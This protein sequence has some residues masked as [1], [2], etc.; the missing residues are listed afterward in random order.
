VTFFL[1]LRAHPL[2]LIFVRHTDPDGWLR[3]AVA[4]AVFDKNF[5]PMK[6]FSLAL[7]VAVCA[8]RV[9]MVLPDLSSP[10]LFVGTMC[11]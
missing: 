2:V 10:D 3:A 7:Q 1:A 4:W 6:G 5:A 9:T 11:A 8:H